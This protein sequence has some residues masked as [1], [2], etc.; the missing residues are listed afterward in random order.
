MAVMDARHANDFWKLSQSRASAVKENK[1]FCVSCDY[2][3]GVVVSF[4]STG[5]LERW[6][7]FHA[8]AR[9]CFLLAP[10]G[11]LI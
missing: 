3:F 9:R 2:M 5:F 7:A 8:D 1:T 4:G 11:L 6:S 10:I